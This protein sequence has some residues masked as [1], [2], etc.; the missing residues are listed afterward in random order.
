LPIAK[1]QLPMGDQ[2]GTG[3]V[4]TAFNS[5]SVKYAAEG[6]RSCSRYPTE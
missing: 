5:V 3:A 1:C 6:D 4:A 2:C